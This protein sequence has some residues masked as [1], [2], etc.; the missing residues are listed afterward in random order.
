M[1]IIPYTTAGTWLQHSA[2]G[3]VVRQER[4]GGALAVEAGAPAARECGVRSAGR[5]R[6]AVSAVVLNQV[7]VARDQ[8]LA[9]GVAGGVLEVADAPGQ[10][11]GVDVAQA[12]VA[13][14]R[15]RALQHRRRGVRR[16]GHPVVLVERGDV[17]RD[18]GRDAGEERRQAAQLR[19]AVVEAGDEQRDDLHPDARAC[20]HWIVSRIGCSRPPSSR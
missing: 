15:G 10:V 4:D 12:R 7:A 14:D 20:S 8:A 5:R 2:A 3:A 13:A 19:V 17:P 6:P 1:P 18:V 9:A 16:I 11:A